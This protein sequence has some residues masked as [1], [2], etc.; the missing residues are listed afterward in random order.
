MNNFFYNNCLNIDPVLPA[1]ESSFLYMAPENISCGFEIVTDKNFMIE[2]FDFMSSI[3]LLRNHIREAL[4][5]FYDFKNENLEVDFISKDN[6]RL[7]ALLDFKD[8][9]EW[10]ENSK[11]ELEMFVEEKQIETL[12]I[13]FETNSETD[14]VFELYQKSLDK[15]ISYPRTV[16]SVLNFSLTPYA[17]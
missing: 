14:E 1:T 2:T 10:Q 12:F 16:S 8:F 5:D 4:K 9:F 11:L 6:D 7:K 3:V 13:N 15:I 17:I